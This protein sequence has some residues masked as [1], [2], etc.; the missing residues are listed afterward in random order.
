MAGEARQVP[1][2]VGLRALTPK[3]LATEETVGNHV[4]MLGSLS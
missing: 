4:A 2:H 1:M 3:S